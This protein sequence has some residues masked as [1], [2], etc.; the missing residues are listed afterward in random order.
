MFG[1]PKGQV[2]PLYKGCRGISLRRV[3]SKRSSSLEFSFI[4]PFIGD[5][6]NTSSVHWSDG[7]VILSTIRHSFDPGRQTP[8]ESQS[9]SGEG[10][11]VL[12]KL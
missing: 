7:N 8:W 4:R 10:E 5:S 2:S 6:V 11:F 1:I 3:V 9:T 12:R